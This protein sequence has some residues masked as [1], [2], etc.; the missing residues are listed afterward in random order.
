MRPMQEELEV[1]SQ[2][3][4]EALDSMC[5]DKEG[6]GQDAL[7]MKDV[8][9]LAKH[10]EALSAITQQLAET[11]NKLQAERSLCEQAHAELARLQSHLQ[12]A[13]HG[14]ISTEEHEKI[15]V[16]VESG[17]PKIRKFNF[18][19]PSLVLLFTMC[20]S[21]VSLSIPRQAH[22][23]GL[24]YQTDLFINCSYRSVYRI[25]WYS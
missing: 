12:D 10:Q 11:E 1:T 23:I 3:D 17:E 6:C 13:R 5:A 19:A 14:M 16:R 7:E 8:V 24:I 25:N 21:F 4:T 9:S 20:I 18:L 22:I 15:R 2:T